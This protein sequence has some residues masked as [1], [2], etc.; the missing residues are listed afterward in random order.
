MRTRAPIVVILTTTTAC[1]GVEGKWVGSCDYGDARYGY[2]AALTLD[3]SKGG[4]STVEGDIVIDMH[5]GQSFDGEVS[6]LRSD[7]YIEMDG[8]FRNDDGP[9]EF[10][11]SG[12]IDET[13][14]EGDCALKIPNGTGAL[15]GTLV[16]ER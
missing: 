7:T 10:S 4:G 16:L 9:Y 5:D 15:T 6:G 12:D 13:V 11:M 14:I 2:S 1:S 3:V 8:T